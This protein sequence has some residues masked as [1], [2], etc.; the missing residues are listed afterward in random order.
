MKRTKKYIAIFLALLILT[1][2]ISTQNVYADQNDTHEVTTVSEEVMDHS[3]DTTI[4]E[5]QV[6]KAVSEEEKEN[7]ETDTTATKADVIEENDAKEEMEK[8][9]ASNDDSEQSTDSKVEE[10]N[11]SET[12]NEKDQELEVIQVNTEELSETISDLYGETDFDSSNTYTTK[13]LIVV[14]DH[15]DFDNGGAIKIIQYDTMY[16]LQYETEE[17]T[18][19]AYKSLKKDDSISSVEIDALVES[20]TEGENNQI[21]DSIEKSELA[22]FLESK[23]ACKEVK[24]A[25]LDTGIH[26]SDESLNNN[27]INLGINLSTSGEENSIEDDNGHGTEM[28]EIIFNNNSYIKL[29]PIKVANSDGKATVLN[30]YIGILKAMEN[31][32]DIINISMNTF[33][34]AN[35]Q[36]LTN[37]TDEATEKG[38]MV[39]VSAGN[40]GIDVANITPSN[41]DSAIVV[42][43]ANSDNSFANY[44]NYGNTV[45]YSSYGSYNGKT[46][47][48]YAAANVTGI[49]ANLLTKDQNI[50]ILEQYSIDLG[51]QGKDIYFGKGLVSLYSKK[52]VIDNEKDNDLIIKENKRQY[53]ELTNLDWKNMSDE[54]LSNK[55][56]EYNVRYI[57]YFLL[58]LSETDLE[59]ILSKNTIL[60]VPTE[61]GK[62]YQIND[63]SEV[64]EINDSEPIIYKHLYE[65]A[66]KKASEM[67]ISEA[68][69]SRSGYFNIKFKGSGVTDYTMRIDFDDVSEPTKNG[70][71]Q[72]VGGYDCYIT[73]KSKINELNF[74]VNGDLYTRKAKDWSGIYIKNASFNKVKYRIASETDNAGDGGRLWTVNTLDTSYVGDSSTNELEIECNSQNCGLQ[75]FGG[76]LYHRTLTI[77]FSIYQN[78]LKINPNGGTHNGYS[79]VY[80]LAT[81]NSGLTTE[82]S[83][84]IRDGYIF[85][86]WTLSNGSNAGG[87]LSGTTYTHVSKTTAETTTTLTAKWEAT[88]LQTVN[89]RYQN[90]N[91]SYGAYELVK[92]ESKL[93]GSQFTWNQAAAGIYEGALLKYTVVGTKPN[94][95]DIKRKSI[96][97]AS[98]SIDGTL[99]KGWYK[100]IPSITFIGNDPN[101]NIS[102]IT[103]DSTLNSGASTT[104]TASPGTNTYKYFATNVNGVESSEQTVTVKAD[105]LAPVNL[106]MTPNTTEWT[107]NP[108]VITAKADDIYSGVYTIELQYTEES[109]NPNWKTYKTENLS[110]ANQASKNFS[111]TEN[112]YYRIVVTDQV[113]FETTTDDKDILEVKNYDPDAPDAN[114]I[115]IEPD[116]IQWVDE[117]TGVEV[118]SYGSDEL[119]GLSTVEVWELKE[120]IYEPTKTQDFNGETTLESTTYDTHLNNSFL[121]NITDQAGNSLQMK[122]EEALEVDN[123]DPQAPELTMESISPQ[124]EYIKTTDGYVIRAVIKDSQ[125]GVGEVALQKLNETGEWVDYK[126]QY[127]II[128]TEGNKESKDSE[129]LQADNHEEELILSKVA[130]E[131]VMV[132]AA[133][134]VYLSSS[135]NEGNETQEE[136]REQGD[137]KVVIEYTVRENGIYRLRGADLV[138]NTAYTNDT[139]EITNLDGSMPVI[140]IEGNPTIWQNSDAIIRVFAKDADSKIVDMTLDGDKK[141]FMEGEDEAFYFTFDATKNQEFTVTATDEA[142]NTTTEIIKVTRIDKEAPI[143]NTDIKKSWFSMIIGDY[144]NLK[145]DTTDDLSGIESVVVRHNGESSL[146]VEYAYENAKINYQGNYKIKEIGD[147]EIIISDH[148]GNVVMQTISESN[149]DFS[150]PWLKVEGNPTIWQNTDAT[151]QVTAFDEDSAIAKMTLNGKEQE[152]ELNNQGEAV[153]AFTATKNE[154]FIVA[155]YDEANHATSQVIEVTKIDKEKPTIETVLTARW[156]EVGYRNLMCEGVDHLSGIDT[157]TLEHEG[158]KEVLSSFEYEKEQKNTANDYQITEN[159]DYVLTITD[160]AGNSDQVTVT[161]EEAKILKAMEVVVSPEKTKY[162]ETDNF[163]KNGM[164]VDAIYNNN[165]RKEDIKDYVILDG[166][167]LVLAQDKINLSYTE[168]DK[169]VYT[170]TTIKVSAEPIVPE[171]PG[172]PE[173]PLSPEEPTPQTPKTPISPN[174]TPVTPTPEIEIKEVEEVKEEVKEEPTKEVKE[175]PDNTGLTDNESKLPIGTIL[176]GAGLF[177]ILL[178]LLLSNVKVYSKNEDGEWR[179][180]GKTRALKAKDKYLV[181]I[182]KLVRI[183]ATSNSYKLVFSKMFKKFHEECELIIKIDKQDYEKHLNKDSDTVY[184]DHKE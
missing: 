88:Y 8:E 167:N 36:I 100:G 155:A 137:T 172:T 170:D 92:S 140:H 85:T 74:D 11:K 165:S 82:V 59:L 51:E 124:E 4:V 151:I 171:D 111:V 1:S 175:L 117:S 121:T 6:D 38:I 10:E 14:S 154:K 42:S 166:M 61:T 90:A 116:T 158:I 102:S 162:K 89:V 33:K 23:N 72:S 13:T 147:Y 169:T 76:N 93:Y 47:T 119:S 9:T 50:S 168:G 179:F 96:V 131:R 107:K 163:I 5:N 128:R 71:F 55:L 126:A 123:I 49:I 141:A 177:I 57:G 95:V 34:S 62:V 37:I 35:S 181:R 112:G 17:A 138:Q 75:Q 164:V 79:T 174:P 148:A 115:G 150:A 83:N 15:S 180:L 12:E 65:S 156:L 122:K 176:A 45:D 60:K 56:L 184:V 26:L 160:H 27:L 78:K 173:T 22:L 28:A 149:L 113:G 84:P 152:F 91:G 68:Y 43:A 146:L 67:S 136:V 80:D 134:N 109:K 41:I 157:I 106:S 19:K 24:V 130:R 94:N 132:M 182:S 139:I 161:E 40:N 153:F 142:G 135:N 48:S 145:I 144:R 52:I 101:L 127:Q 46:G 114:T 77:T 86:G 97:T 129:D 30:T 70:T 87:S 63:N 32:A 58:S 103:V 2:T 39:V 99:L 73:D 21:E 120:G 110:G 66:I 159:G 20:Q 53:E 54:E 16:I 118:T 64:N 105:N 108:V 143:L 81:K 18:K 3:E 104:K 98:H 125:S 69:V 178:F 44:S 31:N 25:I 29:M 133:S 7:S 183:R